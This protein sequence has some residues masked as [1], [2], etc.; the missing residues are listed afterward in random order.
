M[1]QRKTKQKAPTGVTIFGILQLIFSGYTIMLQLFRVIFTSAIFGLFYT[2]VP[3][4]EFK[5]AI[6]ESQLTTTQFGQVAAFTITVNVLFLIIGIV[7]LIAA[8][9]VLM[10]EQWSRKWL[11]G[12]AWSSLALNLVVILVNVVF[13]AKTKDLQTIL[14]TAAFGLFFIFK[15]VYYGLLIWYFSKKEVKEYFAKVKATK[16]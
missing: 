12:T 4:D 2:I 10:R 8:I 11:I 16:K 6:A 7:G 15:A 3:A 1:P 5:K 9:G 14:I 13:I